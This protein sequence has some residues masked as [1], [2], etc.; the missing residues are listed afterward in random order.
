MFSYS[1]QLN[2]F[3]CS[4]PK[5]RF[6]TLTIFVIPFTGTPGGRVGPVTRGVEA[7]LRERGEG[8]R[9]HSVRLFSAPLNVRSKPKLFAWYTPR[10][11]GKHC[12]QVVELL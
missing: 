10:Q 5:T 2:F 11:H 8:N 3:T 9:S 6:R 1:L 12:T 4:L 7:G